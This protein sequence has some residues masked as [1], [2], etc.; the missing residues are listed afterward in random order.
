MMRGTAL[1]YTV[2]RVRDDTFLTNT[3]DG[4]FGRRGRVF[5]SKSYAL[6]L[7]KKYNA[8][9]QEYSLYWIG[10]IDEVC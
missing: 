9:V 7:A 10:Q 1:V 5:K 6:W 4:T 2:Y 8:R 3:T